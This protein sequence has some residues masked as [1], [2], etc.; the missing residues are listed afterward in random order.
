MIA[1]ALA[2]TLAW[3]AAEAQQTTITLLVTDGSATIT[4]FPNPNSASAGLLVSNEGPADLYWI[5][6]TPATV[7]NAQLHPGITICVSQPNPT[8][9][10]V[11]SAIAN[12]G[13]ADNNA[14]S[15][16]GQFVPV[17]TT[18]LKEVPIRIRAIGRCIRQ[19][20]PAEP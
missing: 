17:V 3:S 8:E 2:A 10:S 14:A 20:S 9:F 5:L 12:S 4:I 6:G 18:D 16:S 1:V 7:G 13:R 11:F 19:A 15:N